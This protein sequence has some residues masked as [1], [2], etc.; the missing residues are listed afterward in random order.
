MIYIHTCIVA[1]FSIV[2]SYATRLVVMVVW[3]VVGGYNKLFR[4]FADVDVVLMHLMILLHY[5]VAQLEKW[6]GV[7]STWIQISMYSQK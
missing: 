2:F 3:F 6:Y 5:S 4:G 7:W 1:S